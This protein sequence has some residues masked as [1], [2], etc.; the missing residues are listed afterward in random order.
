VDLDCDEFVLIGAVVGK[1][2]L[3]S[4]GFVQ[5]RAAKSAANA[6]PLCGMILPVVANRFFMIARQTQG[7]QSRG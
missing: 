4:A 6:A 5:G 7:H 1:T 2:G 3:T